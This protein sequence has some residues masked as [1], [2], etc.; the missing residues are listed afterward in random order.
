ML[1]AH[2]LT[3]LYH[4]AHNIMRNVDGLQPQ[5]AFNEL[6]KY[7]FFNQN[8]HGIDSSSEIPSVKDVRKLFRSFLGKTNSW[9]AEIWQDKKIHLSDACL[10]QVHEL[11][12]NIQFNSI[13]YDVR[14]HALK[15]FLTPDIRKGLGIFLTPDDVV[16]AIIDYLNPD[17]HKK[18]L[19]PACG[20][21]T[22]LIEFL[23]NAKKR[24]N[25]KLTIFGFDKNPRM[26]LLANLNLKHI[27]NV[28]FDKTL[29]D[30]LRLNKHNCKYD[31]IFTNPPFGVNLDSRSYDF[32]LYKTCH[33]KNGYYLKSQ[34]SEIVFIERCL[35][36][37]KPGG[38]LAIVVP[39]SIATNNNL[40]T[41]R[42][43]L[44][45]LGFIYTI[46]S[47]P[48]ETFASMGT[49]TTTIVLFIKKYKNDKEKGELIDIPIVNISNVGYDSTGR[50]RVGN[51]L[52]SF[53]KMAKN[54]LTKRKSSRFV[55]LIL[56]ENKSD[57]FI[58]LSASFIQNIKSTKGVKLSSI[59]NEI[60]TGR[61]PARCSYTEQGYFIVKVG[62]LNGSGIIWKSRDRN[63]ISK[64]EIKKR[65]KSPKSLIV[66]KYDILLT[67]SAHN[68]I[69]IAKKIDIF[70]NRPSFIRGEISFVGE[71]MLIRPNL[72]KINP[73][74]LLAYLRHPKTILNIQKMVRGQTAHLH[75]K[76]LSDLVIPNQVFNKNTSFKKVANLIEE[77]TLLSEK[78][79]LNIMKQNL[80]LSKI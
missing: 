55:D 25:D 23:K 69:Y 13:N 38:S 26:L 66:R 32:S 2:Q 65:V 6:L 49:Q 27:R 3:K 19:D 28:K 36:L 47:L 45:E 79:N 18:V 10:T 17:P 60:C 12:L 53:S 1:T 22:F 48:P 76:D 34:T 7:M 43:Y 50:Q 46:M 4:K 21:G 77:Q 41:A 67:S 62:N 14:S 71:I 15:E 11:L 75:S 8:Y 51:E 37:L 20:S 80:A 68:P 59:C 73:F 54:A 56:D 5:E 33:D 70:L 44:S 72:K 39:K 57:T 78:L 61:T 24:T 40:I 52:P 63:F 29:Q 30:S 35:Q 42:D 58:N 9:S 74:L 64:E 16:S 31:F